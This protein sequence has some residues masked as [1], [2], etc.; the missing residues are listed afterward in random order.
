MK[1][2]LNFILILVAFF[3]CYIENVYLSLFPLHPGDV[4]P[5]TI[6]SQ[7][8][9]SFDQEKALGGKRKMALSQ[10]VPLYTYIPDSMEETKE[11]IGSLIKKVFSL[12]RRKSGAWKEL[13]SYLQEEFGV[14]VDR[15]VAVK[16]LRYRKLESTLE[17]IMTVEESILRDKI[18]EDSEPFQGKNTIEILYPKPTGIVIHSTNEVITLEAAKLLLQEK[19]NQLFWQVDNDVLNLLLEISLTT[20]MPNLEYNHTEN[21]KRI[22]SIIERYPSKV[23]TFGP[24]D[25][26]V[27][28]R[29]VLAEEDV[30]LLAAYEKDEEKNLYGEVA[31]I[32]TAILLIVMFYNLLLSR[33]L[34]SA[35]QKKPPYSILLASLII[36][37]FISKACL[38]FTPF[39]IFAVPFAFLPFLLILLQNE[40]TSAAWTTVIGAML[41]CLF[42]GRTLEILFFFIFGGLSAVLVTFK[43]RKRIH[44]LLPSL[45]VGIINAVIIMG[46]TIHWE[47]VIA[48]FGMGWQK[49]GASSL[50]EFFGTTSA[51]YIGWAFLGG[52]ASGP[53]A[54]LFLPLLELS[55]HTASTF[56]LNKFADLQHPLMR[57]LLTK[58]PATYQHTM[59]VAYLAQSVGEAI[60]ANTLL[61][62]I[63]AYY[64]DI[65]KMADPKFFTE[66]QPKGENPH[67]DLG[68]QESANLIINHVT[69]GEKLAREFGVPEIIVDFIPQH[70]GTQLVEYFY[71]K[72]VE[73]SQGIE[74]EEQDFRYPGPKPQSTEAAILMIVDAV[75]AASRSIKEPTRDNIHNMIR[76]L[77]VKR[78]E[79]GQFEE[80]NLSTNYLGKIV[81]TL[82]DSL[83]AALHPRLQYPW[84]KKGKK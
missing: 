3:S 79:D 37:V 64:H 35:W 9:F 47:S 1:L 34:G 65:G 28:S 2:L 43:L 57:D 36:T 55:W 4:T 80:C 21:D 73:N 19:V 31:W 29:K 13:A 71:N 18:A 23:I 20:L 74:F 81:Q 75:E 14:E 51:N 22:E 67:D 70:H 39:P 6:R 10:Y 62:R 59:T 30:L 56:K 5:F 11:R 24:G 84:Q 8:K 48:F 45:V 61:L 16:L 42:A 54:I 15:R 72:A 78:I 40:R 33:I 26:L 68:W 38:L 46:F 44:I 25:T 17:G 76:L 82:V 60:G 12:Q 83:E 41:V 50:K 69:Y 32:L 52:I 53:F 77:I 63:G 49:I 58:A 27:P 7:V 66:N